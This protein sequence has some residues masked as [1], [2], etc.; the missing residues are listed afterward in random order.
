MT[1]SQNTKAVI[2][3]MDGL[4]IDSEQAWEK[5]DAEL[6]RRYNKKHTPEI[7]KHIM[8]KK[9]RENVA[10][11]IKEFGFESTVDELLEERLALVY[12]VL[13]ADLSLMEGAEALVY[14]LHEQK[15]KMAIATSGHSP[16]RAREIT[17]KLGLDSYMTV[18]VSGDDVKHGKPEPDIFLKAAELIGVDPSDCLVFE[19]APKGVQAGKAAGMLVYGVNKDKD[20]AMKLKEAKAD[21]VFAS[22]AEVT[23]L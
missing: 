23:V 16:K 20:L 4:L 19:D 22:L 14:A 1:I 17:E 15:Y 5:A 8:G 10:Y 12:E 11:F 21:Q 13:L 2:F 6:F 7:N 3:D 18:I 9:P